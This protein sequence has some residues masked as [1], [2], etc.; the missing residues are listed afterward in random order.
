M[1]ESCRLRDEV[2]R[3]ALNGAAPDALF[4]FVAAILI[5][6]SRELPRVEAFGFAGLGAS[7]D[8]VYD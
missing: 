7:V 8:H 4:V 5:V 2:L 1:V 3:K 6:K